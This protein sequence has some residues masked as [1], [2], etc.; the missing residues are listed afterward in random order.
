MSELNGITYKWNVN[1]YE[2]TLFISESKTRFNDEGVSQLVHFDVN[3]FRIKEGFWGIDTFLK[4]INE[5]KD[6]FIN[7]TLYDK[8][9]DECVFTHE[10]FY[11]KI[12]SLSDYRVL[13]GKDYEEFNNWIITC[14]SPK[15]EG[16]IIK[17]NKL[18][19]RICCM[20]NI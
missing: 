19:K 3:G 9:L 8:I 1:D 5:E 10:D 12:N 20:K 18:M 16:R 13:S 17:I 15:N 14:T 6:F 2:F 11:F 4:S 7:E